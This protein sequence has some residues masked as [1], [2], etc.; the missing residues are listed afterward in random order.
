MLRL[1]TLALISGA[2]MLVGATQP[3]PPGRGLVF[4]PNRGQAPVDAQWVA[5]GPSYKVLLTGDGLTMMVRERN[6]RPKYSAVRMKLVGGRPWKALAGFDATGEVTNYLRGNETKVTRIPHYAK[7][8]AAG[9]YEGID[10]VFYDHGGN[11]EYDFEVAAGADPGN[12]VLAFDGVQ[13]MRIDNRS[14]EL[15]L[16]TWGGSELRHAR[17]LVYQQVGN[18]RVEVAGGYE[19][20][21]NG[22]AAFTLAHYDSRHPLIIDPAIAIE[23]I[24]LSSPREVLQR[25]EVGGGGGRP[26]PPTLRR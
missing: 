23:R 17:P 25:K 12:I 21:D 1:F 2:S 16:T 11:L 6:S 15:I 20:L 14:G 4:E 7:V 3:H 26:L 22:R 9:V 10:L 13:R 19:L 5:Q 8:R 24:Y 18:E